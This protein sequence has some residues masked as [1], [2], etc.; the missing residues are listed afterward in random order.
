MVLRWLYRPTVA[1]DREQPVGTQ[2]LQNTSEFSSSSQKPETQTMKP[3]VQG[4]KVYHRVRRIWMEVVEYYP[5]DDTYY[6]LVKDPEY[7]DE[8][9][10]SRES[11]MFDVLNES[12]PSSKA[13]SPEAMRLAIAH[14]MGFTGCVDPGCEY[15]K[16]KHLH[17]EGREFFFESYTTP[18]HRL[19]DW[20]TNLNDCFRME[21][22][23]TEDE[24]RAY[25]EE[26]ESIC[27]EATWTDGK[28]H[29]LK[30]RVAH[31][32]PAHRCQAFLRIKN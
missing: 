6:A 28:D 7:G 18:D 8:V 21:E 19:P 24:G 23:L 11:V 25:T 30:F 29:W 22:T 12:F 26:L 15:R 3:Q 1:Q 16:A 17:K 2:A 13:M 31:A 20:T 27:Q 5:D 32:L 9:A 14:H 10:I 4:E